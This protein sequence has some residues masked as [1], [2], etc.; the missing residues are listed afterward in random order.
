MKWTKWKDAFG[1]E[2]LAMTE[3]E[4]AVC[5]CVTVAD[6]PKHIRISENSQEWM[7]SDNSPFKRWYY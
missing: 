3:S 7:D 2:M 4:W 6:M 1:N 5:V